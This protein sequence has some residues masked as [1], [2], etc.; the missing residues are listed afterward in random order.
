MTCLECL[1]LLQR[2]LDGDMPEQSAGIRRAY[3]RLLFVRRL[4]CGWRGLSARAEK[5]ACPSARSRFQST[6]GR[7]WCCAIVASCSRRRL[8]RR[9]RITMV[10]AA[11]ILIMAV[12]GYFLMPF[13][14]T[15]P[16]QM[17]ILRPGKQ[18]KA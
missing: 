2:A 11:S 8:R 3:R 12:A 5:D 10:L 16:R 6:D 4:A 14:R 18:R 9:L 1:L 17:P 7:D 13:R 15:L